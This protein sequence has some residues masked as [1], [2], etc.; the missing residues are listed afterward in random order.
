MK[1]LSISPKVP[2]PAN[3]GGKLSIFGVLKSLSTR[4]HKIDFVAYLKDT[5]Y[6]YAISE[7]AQY[8]NPHVLD[9][10]T[11]NNYW[12]MF[13]NLFS[14]VPY[15]VSKYH[16]SE[17]EIFVKDY[18]KVKKPDIIHVTNLHMGW[19]ID[20]IREVSDIPVV[21][22]QE[23]L[24]MT[25]MQR[26]SEKQAN[27]F[28]KKYSYMQYKKFIKYEPALCEKFDQCI[29]ITPKDA[30]RLNELN[31]KV[32]TSVIPVGVEEKLLNLNNP[33]KVPFSLAHIG[34]L[35]W[36]PNQDSLEWF[37]NDIFPRVLN[38]Y[39]QT[40]LHVYGGGVPDNFIIPKEIRLNVI[41]EGFVDDLWSEL[42]SRS[43]AIV[44]LRIGSGLRVKILEMMAVGQNII[45]TS[46]GKEGINVTDENEI[47]IADDAE[48]FAEKIIS[49]FD[50]SYNSKEMIKNGRRLI[51]ERYTW[52]TVAEQFESV[53]Q[54]L[55]DK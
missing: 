7:L 31:P 42:L 51:S 41:I 1:I 18:L 11:E 39:P 8:A 6:D 30:E 34:H 52:K 17:L 27:P 23:N 44:P 36:Y 12:K 22:R 47:L 32:K 45:S 37:L 28:I 29:M 9:V 15:N 20:V 54:N 21:L 10:Q 26:F 35:D 43:L 50:E 24:E 38:K 25:I 3:D 2:I 5:P 46:I 33:G 49:Y 48:T 16:R 53:Y 13:L 40:K 4:G 55:L 14:N 19:I